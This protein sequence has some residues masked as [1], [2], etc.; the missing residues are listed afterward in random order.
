MILPERLRHFPHATLIVASDTIAAK[1]FLVGGDSL[2][3]LDGV[4]VP[5]ETGR[6]GEGSIEFFPDDAA[7]LHS[8]AKELASRIA[9]LAR[10]HGIPHIHLVMPAEIEHLVTKDLPHDIAA[11][12]GAKLH[13]DVMKESDVAIVERVVSRLGIANE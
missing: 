11:T 9:T 6:D 12:I 2:E 8:F 10:E 3:E 1:F 5:K 13:L 7:R 4:A